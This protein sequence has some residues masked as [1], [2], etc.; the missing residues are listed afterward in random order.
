M[1]GLQIL[2]LQVYVETTGPG[3]RG[4]NGTFYSRRLR[5]PYYR[6]MYEERLGRWAGYRLTPYVVPRAL[7]HANASVPTALLIQLNEHYA[8]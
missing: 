7:R 5:G 3:A 8:D 4:D 2:G 6:W 1:T